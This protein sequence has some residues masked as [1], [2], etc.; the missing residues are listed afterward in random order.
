MIHSLPPMIGSAVAMIESAVFIAPDTIPISNVSPRE[1][2]YE[3]RHDGYV[4]LRHGH[5]TI[6]F[7]SS[8]CFVC[9]WCHCFFCGRCSSRGGRYSI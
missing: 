7:S 8:F 5:F 6:A 1:D 2:K 4:Y 3:L 9:P